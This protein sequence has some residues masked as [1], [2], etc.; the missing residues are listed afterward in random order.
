MPKN[1]SIAAKAQ[2]LLKILLLRD[3][4]KIT[5]N[6]GEEIL[7]LID[8]FETSIRVASKQVVL[9]DALLHV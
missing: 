1:D 7:R 2:L 4:G 8:D 5:N 3:Q 9:S 6:E